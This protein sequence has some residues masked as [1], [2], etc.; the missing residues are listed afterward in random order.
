MI[1]MDRKGKKWR[2]NKKEGKGGEE[3]RGVVKESKCEFSTLLKNIVQHYRR[4]KDRPTRIL[5]E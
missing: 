5:I 3:L 1:E 4:Q 2:E